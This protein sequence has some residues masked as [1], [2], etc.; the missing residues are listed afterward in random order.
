MLSD[1]SILRTIFVFVTRKCKFVFVLVIEPFFVPKTLFMCQH[2]CS[3]W[4][5]YEP[6]I[7]RDLHAYKYQNCCQVLQCTAQ[8]AFSFSAWQSHYWKKKRRLIRVKHSCTG[9][10]SLTDFLLRIDVASIRKLE[11]LQ[12]AAL[13]F[14]ELSPWEKLLHSWNDHAFITMTITGFDC[15]SCDSLLVKFDPIFNG[16]TPFDKSGMILLSLSF[17]LGRR[18]SFSQWIVMDLF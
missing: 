8:I 7:C 17:A 1:C 11:N 10:T 6:H 5:N 16:H 18:E 13:I 14:L 9:R 2:I 15:I 4:L 12:F 3:L